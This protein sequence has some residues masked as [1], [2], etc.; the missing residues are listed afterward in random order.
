MSL[1]DIHRVQSF[2]LSLQDSICHAIENIDQ[3]ATFQQDNWQREAGGG[4]RTRV[5]TPKVLFL[6][7]RVL[8]FPMFMEMPYLHQPR[9]IALN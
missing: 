5:L 9:L 8:I 6:N 1:P 7:K 2:F 3:K 4:G